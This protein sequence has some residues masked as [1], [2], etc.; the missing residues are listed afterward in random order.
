MTI[1]G[2]ITYKGI[3]STYSLSYDNKLLTYIVNGKMYASINY[4]TKNYKEIFSVLDSYSVSDIELTE[5]E[6][7]TLKQIYPNFSYLENYEVASM[8]VDLI[9]TGSHNIGDI[10]YHTNCIFDG[11]YKTVIDYNLDIF[12]NIKSV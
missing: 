1:T 4:V 9:I 10:I 3:V 6:L 8:V 2:N 12:K 11:D 7:E 5:K